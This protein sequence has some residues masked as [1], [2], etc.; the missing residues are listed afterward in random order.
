MD[1]SWTKKA[2]ML[3]PITSI[4]GCVIGSKIFFIGG[5]LQPGR[6]GQSTVEVYDTK[7]DTWSVMPDLKIL[8]AALTA[9]ALNNKIYAIGGSVRRWPYHPGD[10]CRVYKILKNF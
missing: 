1:S 9:V 3:T 10:S 6:K 5:A 8:R 7:T 2:D 4:S